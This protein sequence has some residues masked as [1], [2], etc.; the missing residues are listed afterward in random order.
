M[1]AKR[2]TSSLYRALESFGRR[3]K[4]LSAARL[5]HYPEVLVELFGEDAIV[6]AAD[7]QNAAEKTENALK[8]IIAAIQN[9]TDR[10]IADAIFALS[11][12]FWDMNVTERQEYVDREEQPLFTRELFKTQRARI[13]RDIASALP[14]VV[15]SV[16]ESRVQPVLSVEARHAARQL[17]RYLQDA[18]LRIDAFDFCV[19]ASRKIEGDNRYFDI[20][21]LVP[22]KRT[23]FFDETLWSYTYSRKYFG[24][25]LHQ[26]TTRNYLRERMPDDWWRGTRLDI[27]F[28]RGDA[29]VLFSA[30]EAA[31]F[32]DPSSFGD[33]L[34]SSDDGVVL[35]ERWMLLLGSKDL[36]LFNCRVF[37]NPTGAERRRLVG[38][39][40]WLCCALQSEFE[41]ETL[42]TLAAEEEFC[43]LTDTIAMFGLMESK[44]PDHDSDGV[45]L[46]SLVEDALKGHPY[47]YTDLDGDEDS[48]LIDWR[49]AR[50]WWR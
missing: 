36:D 4:R 46:Y 40:K 12:E 29:E 1:V 27:P 13:L 25:C 41:D 37:K 23:L 15:G 10:R 22:T 5:E 48:D 6:S 32:D 35:Y 45:A 19:H 16:E 2:E 49:R 50:A 8:G 44:V 28:T 17:Y 11:P 39:M 47:P 24:Q 42:S 20:A 33:E 30:L 21:R 9:P 26:P 31:P 18:I 38:A 14:G 43:A 7:R 3:A 34:L